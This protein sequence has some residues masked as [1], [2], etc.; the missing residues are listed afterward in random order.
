MDESG[1]TFVWVL[2][3]GESSIMCSGSL[4]SGLCWWK[5]ILGNVSGKGGRWLWEQ[6]ERNLGDGD[7]TSFWESLWVGAESL[8]RRFLRLFHLSNLREVKVSEMG[9][10]VNGSW[11]GELKWCRDIF[12]REILVI[13]ELVCLLN[14]YLPKENLDASWK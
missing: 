5:E 4:D 14:R 8:K 9:M 13:N 2:E 1:E 3:V 12:Y 10:W 11:K 7:G 6:L